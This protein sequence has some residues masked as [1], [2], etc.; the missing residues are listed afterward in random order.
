VARSTAARP[1]ASSAEGGGVLAQA[2]SNT[3][4]ATANGV[5]SNKAR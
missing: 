4:P 5:V 1:T 3:K 2:D